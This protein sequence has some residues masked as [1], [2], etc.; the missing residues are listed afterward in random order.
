MP[1]TTDAVSSNLDQGSFYVITFVSNLPEL[2]GFLRVLKMA[3]NTIKQT[4]QTYI[5]SITRNS[6]TFILS[7]H[8]QNNWTCLYD[9]IN[10]IAM[11][12]TVSC[13]C[14]QLS[15]YWIIRHMRGCPIKSILYV[16]RYQR[17][18]QKSI[19]RRR[20]DIAMAN[21]AKKDEWWSTK[22]HTVT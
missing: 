19:T 7:Y 5:Y 9:V 3:L 2:G 8:L 12:I 4:K 6:F 16:W 1:V 15:I 13:I 14:A 11:E 10:G 21:R 17:C 20:T 22:H 18:N